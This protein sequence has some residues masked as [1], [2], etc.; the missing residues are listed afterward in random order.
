MMRLGKSPVRIVELPGN[1]DSDFATVSPDA[2]GGL[3]VASNRMLHIQ[4][5][6]VQ[7]QNLPGMAGV[8]IRNTLQ[9]RDRSLWMGTVGKGLYHVTPSAIRRYDATDGLVNNYVRS[10][11]QARDGS[12]WIGTD[13][14]L[15]HLDSSGFHNFTSQ[16]GLAYNSVRTVIED[17]NG[18]I[19]I[20]TDHG[21]SHRRGGAFVQDAATRA[22]SQE[23]VWSLLEDSDGGIW[24]GTRGDGLFHFSNGRLAHFDAA[25][26]LVSDIVYSILEDPLKR[27]WI[28][29]PAAVMLVNRDALERHEANPGGDVPMRIFPARMAGS[30]TQ[31]YGGLQPSGMLARSG[32]ACFPS[33]HGL[34]MI[35]PDGAPPPR[36]ARLR[37]SALF[38]DGQR[39]ALGNPLTLPAQSTRFAIAYD[40]VLLR[41]LGELRSHYRL[42]GFDQG[43]VQPPTNQTVAPYTNLRP[44]RYTFTLEAW[45]SGFPQDKSFTTLIVVKRP[46]YYQTFW[47]WALFILLSAVLLTAAYY[48]RISLHRRRFREILAERARLAREVHDTLLQGCASVSAL[49]HAAAGN[50]TGGDESRL[51]MIRFASTQMKTT[52]DEARHAIANLRLKRPFPVELS[53]D[54]KRMTERVGR[55]HGIDA[56]FTAAGLPFALTPSTIHA[57]TMVAREAVFNAILHANAQKIRVSLEFSPSELVIAVSDDGQ[58]FNPCE[59]NMEEHFGLQGMR[60]RIAILGG[61]LA[62]DSQL[63]RGTTVRV[64]LL[65]DE[66]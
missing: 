20:G 2:D 53:A 30:G 8:Q 55:E 66:A 35:R 62:I 51:H 57:L 44:G 25:T 58:G 13:N 48:W 45:D 14:G 12:L 5:N 16:G 63:G 56:A 21:L 27:L 11:T 59:S 42:D 15:S 38:V 43:W 3:W 9:D 17:R 37:I 6:Q 31:F 1:L 50:E 29:T 52:M 54:L 65:R 23:K 22:L 64:Q 49:L 47:F 28:G 60:E 7:A 18:E 40:L 36:P 34:W 41:P 33:T 24:I 10:L 19:W 26:G 46:Y 4:N 39:A 61:E 32:E